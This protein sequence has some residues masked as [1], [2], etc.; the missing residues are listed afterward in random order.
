[1]RR[2][3]EGTCLLTMNPIQAQT[4]IQKLYNNRQ[5][6]VH[7]VRRVKLVCL[8]LMTATHPLMNAGPQTTQSRN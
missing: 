4:S 2:K 3:R 1:M 5:I 6:Q 7:F 8:F